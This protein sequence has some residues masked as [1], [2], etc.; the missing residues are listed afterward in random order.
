MRL[1]RCLRQLLL[2]AILLGVYV[3]SAPRAR[4]APPDAGVAA[5]PPRPPPTSAREV[6]GSADRYV[7]ARAVVTRDSG[8]PEPG[9][10]LSARFTHVFDTALGSGLGSYT[11][12]RLGI[13]GRWARDLSPR[14]QLTLDLAAELSDFSFS[15]PAS[16]PT[17]CKNPKNT[18]HRKR[19]KKG[20]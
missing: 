10:W 4:A 19:K 12:N 18:T 3:G 2:G 13:D 5:I 14:L 20:F 17:H 6:V 8:L 1:I 15:D 7:G 9:R 11:V 16:L